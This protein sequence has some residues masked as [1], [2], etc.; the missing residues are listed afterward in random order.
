[1][2]INY[3]ILNVYEVEHKKMKDI[4]NRKLNITYFISIV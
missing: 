1:M 4:I 2:G 3:T